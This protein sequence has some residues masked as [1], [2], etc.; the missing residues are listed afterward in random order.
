MKNVGEGAVARRAGMVGRE[1]EL[2][3]LRGFVEAGPAVGR[4]CSPGRLGSGRRRCGRR[5]LRSRVSAGSGARC[6]AEQCRGAAVVRCL[7][8]SVRGVDTGALIGVPA[9]QR[10]AL[11]IA[12]L[13]AEPSGM[14]PEPHA[15]ALGFLNGLRALAAERSLLIAVDDVQWLDSPSA[16]ALVF[17]ARRLK[18]EPVAFLL[19][20]RPGRASALEQALRRGN[21][22]SWRLGRWVSARRAGFCLTGSGLV[23]SR[24][25]LR[26]IVHSTLGNPLFV[27][28]VGRT[29]LGR[30][31]RA[32]V[33][34]S[35]SRTRSRI[36]SGGVWGDW[37]LRCAGCCWRS[38]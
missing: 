12:L 3:V 14:P 26:R 28:E 24:Q 2:G 13:R 9:P 27:L 21:S 16:D 31:R 38:R 23:L 30:E 22:S 37:R 35:R 6:S 15:I 20:R 34:T 11:E 5:G 8:R 4:W 7:D 18:D 19:A 17:A 10:S 1:S 33:R 36:S 32:Q 25:I 29:L